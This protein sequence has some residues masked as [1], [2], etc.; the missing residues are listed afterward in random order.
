MKG[1]GCRVYLLFEAFGDD[2]KEKLHARVARL[3]CNFHS[4]KKSETRAKSGWVTILV[5]SA[6]TSL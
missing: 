5:W 6:C 1:V 2:I 3:Q 4:V